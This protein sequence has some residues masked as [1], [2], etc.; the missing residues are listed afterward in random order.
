[1]SGIHNYGKK[2]IGLD[3]SGYHRLGI[4]IPIVVIT[5]M[6]L[7][8]FAALVIDGGRLYVARSELQRTS[9]AG[10]LAAALSMLPDATNNYSP[11]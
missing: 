3:K 8:G 9:D 11:T 2:S 4:A 10:A 7:L 1:M 6:V 5:I